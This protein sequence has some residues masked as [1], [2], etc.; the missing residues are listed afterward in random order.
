MLRSYQSSPQI[1]IEKVQDALISLED[2]MDE[3][4]DFE[5]ARKRKKAERKKAE[6]KKEEGKELE[7]T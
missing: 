5:T 4:E 1:V 3:A 6:R 7:G 2:E